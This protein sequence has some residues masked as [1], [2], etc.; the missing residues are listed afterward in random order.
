M[1]A[2]DEKKIGIIELEF[3]SQ[4]LLID[5]QIIYNMSEESNKEK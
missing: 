1:E 5:A 3:F 4:T 2:N